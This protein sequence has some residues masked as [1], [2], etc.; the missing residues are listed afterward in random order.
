M[1][2]KIIN[3]MVVIISI[4]ILVLTLLN[5]NLVYDSINY[6]LNLWVKNIIPSLFPFFIIS[7]ILVNYDITRYIPKFIK[8]IFRYIFNISD[9]GLTIFLLSIISGFPSN[10]KITR[11]MLEKRNIDTNEANHI[12][13]FS[14]FSNPLFILITIPIF[15]FHNENVGLI[16]LISH[17]LSN[18]ILG[19]LVRNKNI[20]RKNNCSKRIDN[21]DFSIVFIN[22][23]KKSINTITTIG[24]I[25]T[26]FLVLASLITHFLSLNFYNSMLFKGIM[27]MTIGIDSL[28]KLKLPLIYKLTITSMFLAFGGLSIHMQVINEIMDTSIKY[29]YYLKGRIIQ[30]VIS[31]LLTYIICLFC[32]TIS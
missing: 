20:I 22:S 3:F 4:L 31:G 32:T 18:I 24:G 5:K 26:V 28:V 23:I 9:N 19:I 13:I 27:E 8:R 11:T 12:L 15:F 14:H 21:N 10:A 16:L 17:Y 6:S 2:K 1:K 29:N 25:V 7:D 30:M